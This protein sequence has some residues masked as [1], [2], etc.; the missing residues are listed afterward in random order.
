M[1]DSEDWIKSADDLRDSIEQ[2]KRPQPPA[3]QDDVIHAANTLEVLA[4]LA[5]IR[6]LREAIGTKFPEF[7][8]DRVDYVSIQVDRSLWLECGGHNVGD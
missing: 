3:Q 7:E 6:R 2:L 8:D 5:E 1:K 4:L